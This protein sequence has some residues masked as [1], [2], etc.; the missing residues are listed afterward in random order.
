MHSMTG[1]GR[2]EAEGLGSHFQIDIKSVNHRYLD[3]GVHMPGQLAA[4]ENLIRRKLKESGSSVK[5]TAVWGYG[6]KL[7]KADE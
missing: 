4:L 7:E 3:I 1:Y 2:G 5:I 6:Y